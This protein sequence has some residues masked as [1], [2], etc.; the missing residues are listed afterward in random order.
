[1]PNANYAVVCTGPVLY[2]QNGGYSFGPKADDSA[3]TLSLKLLWLTLDFQSQLQS[4]VLLC[5][6]TASLHTH[7]LT[8]Q[9]LTTLRSTLIAN[10]PTKI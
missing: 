1:M 10:P 5:P 9:L 6:L 8:I 2:D 3:G 4:R 7:N